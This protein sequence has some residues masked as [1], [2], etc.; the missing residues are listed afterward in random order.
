M[1]I[2]PVILAGGRG[3]R[4]WPLSRELHPKQLLPLADGESMLQQTLRRLSALPPMTPPVV[5]C[6]E[7]HRFMVAEQVRAL[8]LEAVIL[9]EPVGRETAPA[10]ALAALEAQRRTAEQEVLLLVLPVDHQLERL[11]Q[12]R[13]ALERALPAAAAGHLVTFGIVAR[14][15]ETA[16]GYIEPGEALNGDAEIFAVRR[17]VEKPDAAGAAACLVAGCLWNS[18]ILVVSAATYLAELA[19]F[20]P[21]MA[22][23]VAQCYQRRRRERDFVYLDHDSLAA[24]PSRSLDHAVLE[25]T[26]RAAV[27]PLACG[28]DDIGSWPSLAGS[29]AEQRD[30]AGNTARGPVV[31]KNS[32]N[33]QAWSSGRLL[34]LLGVD[35]LVVVETADA[36]LVAHRDQVQD[37]RQLVAELKEQGWPEVISHPAGHRN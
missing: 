9:V 31:I 32:R 16:Y 14:R 35:D 33:C 22:A 29:G 28:W 12:F 36:V 25:R 37:I 27:V 1:V 5:V 18:G 19:R 8:E 3:T 30:S 6:L 17:F 34:T 13:L 2:V 26:A 7:E 10:V 4:L 23:R 24:S 11:E 21:E 20:E 15:P